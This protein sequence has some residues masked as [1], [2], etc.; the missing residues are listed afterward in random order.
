MRP[1][2]ERLEHVRYISEN[3]SYLRGLTI[4]LLG[5]PMLVIGLFRWWMEFTNYAYLPSLTIFSVGLF[6]LVGS[7]I[8]FQYRFVIKANLYYA[9][10]F[11]EVETSEEQKRRQTQLGWIV[12]VPMFVAFLFHFFFG[13]HNIFIASLVFT[14]GLESLLLSGPRLDAKIFGMSFILMSLV[15]FFM[16]PI[17]LFFY[18][19]LIVGGALLMQGWMNHSYLRRHPH[20]G[21]QHG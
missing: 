2:E 6:L 20:F 21:E 12:V 18:L 1:T 7:L 17:D 11:G 5:L 19:D 8:Y 16:I 9:H 4:V 10:T 14:K 3:F 15:V 13:V